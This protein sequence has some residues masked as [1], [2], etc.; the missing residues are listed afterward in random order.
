MTIEEACKEIEKCKKEIEKYKNEI[1]RLEN[2]PVVV[3]KVNMNMLRE[4]CK[5]LERLN[6]EFMRLV[7]TPVV[8][9]PRDS[10]PEGF[11]LVREEDDEQ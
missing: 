4:V 7:N 8:V 1:M 3:P 10:K 2:C 11:E 9:I 5:E 6:Y